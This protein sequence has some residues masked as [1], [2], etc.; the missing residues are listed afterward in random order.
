MR[1]L[2]IEDENNQRILLRDL[3]KRESYEVAEAP[4]GLT[5]LNQYRHGAFDLVLLDQ[6]LPDL[7]GIDV[8]KQLKEIDPL[9]PVI[10]LTAYGN[11]Q[12]AVAAMRAGAYHYLTKPVAVDEFLIIIKKALDDVRLRQENIELKQALRDQY[13][14]TEIVFA[15]PKMVKVMSLVTAAAASEA[16]VLITGESGTGKEIIARTIHGL[17]LRKDRLFLPIHI[18]ALPETLIEAQLFG[19]ERGAFTGADRRHLGKFEFADKGT[20][21][22]DEIGDLSPALQVKLLRV[23]QE[24]K[25]VRL[26]RN[27]ETAVDVRIISATNKILEEEVSAGRFRE[28]LYYRLNV[29]RIHLPA[30]RERKEDIPILTEQFIKN[31]AARNRK[32]IKGISKDA[33]KMLLRY[34]FPGN[35]R[36]LEN[37][38]ERAVIFSSTE[39]ITTND[40]PI[41]EKN[42]K[43]ALTHGLLVEAVEDLEIQMIK[44]A[45]EKNNGNQT[46]AANDLGISERVL[47]YKIKKYRIT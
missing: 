7:A 35:V 30:L 8:L 4:D 46:R 37:I 17:S 12:D 31:F 27:E 16:H 36:E 13:R 45:L 47:R 22:L 20:I 11:I 28:D 1:I 6:R 18:A 21:F 39:Q 38:I 40:L 29:I 43:R 32:A 41:L 15:S 24:K 42:T 9:T 10:L 2:I 3:M 34:P 5:G 14:G 44:N 33:L 19:Y 23:V 26:G 25:I